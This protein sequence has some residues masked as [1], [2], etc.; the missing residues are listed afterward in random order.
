MAKDRNVIAA[1]FI[2]FLLKNI[3]TVTMKF[4]ALS[5]KENV[6]QVFFPP[7]YFKLHFFI[8]FLNFVALTVLVLQSVTIIRS[9]TQHWTNHIRII[10]HM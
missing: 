10:I 7:Q 5:C 4:H 9:D 3:G 2:H 8:S 1:T 6:P